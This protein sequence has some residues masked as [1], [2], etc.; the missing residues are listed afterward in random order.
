MQGCLAVLVLRVHVRAREEKELKGIDISPQSS[1]VK[2]SLSD[3]VRRV[4]IF[5]FLE[6]LLESLDVV[7]FSS[8]Q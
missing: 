2:G 3:H 8:M 5:A 4:H 6:K 1:D 7:F